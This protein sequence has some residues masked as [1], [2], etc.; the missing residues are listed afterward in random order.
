M[1]LIDAD[2]LKV[3]GWK[4]NRIVYGKTTATYEIKDLDD[5]PTV[6]AVPVVRCK[7]CKYCSIDRY[8]DGNI[9]NY[10]CIE[11]DCGVEA[12]GFCSWGDRRIDG[13]DC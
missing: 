4:L 6:D 9:P 5:V 3:Q 10:V 12:D 2:R 13:V 8:A 11:M 7:D 1:R